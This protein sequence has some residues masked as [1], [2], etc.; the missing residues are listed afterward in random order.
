MADRE[1]VELDETITSLDLEGVFVEEIVVVTTEVPENVANELVAVTDGEDEYVGPTE[2]VIQDGLADDDDNVVGLVDK[3]CVSDVVYVADMIADHV[4][5]EDV[6]DADDEAVVVRVREFVIV[7]RREGDT[8]DEDVAEKVCTSRGEI[9]I[10][11]E[12]VPASDWLL[13]DDVDV[14]G[15]EEMERRGVLLAEDDAVSDFDP[16]TDKVDDGVCDDVRDVDV[17]RVGSRELDGEFDNCAEAE[18]LFDT[19]AD[20]VS[21]AEVDCDTEMRALAD[22]D[23]DTFI[24]AEAET[25][26]IV[27]R[28]GRATVPDD[29]GE[30][31]DDAELSV[32]TVAEEPLED[33]A[34]CI[35]VPVRTIDEVNIGKFEMVVDT[36]AD[37]DMRALCVTDTSLV[38]EADAEILYSIDG[39]NT[40]L[41]VADDVSENFVTDMSDETVLDCDARVEKELEF[42]SEGF[43]DDDLD[44][45]GEDVRTLESEYCVVSE[46]ELVV[47]ITTVD[48]PVA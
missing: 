24:D 5:Q 4:S 18:I 34:D 21:E 7:V 45:T 10:L 36:V 35:V 47:D 38:T 6:G 28:E 42:V 13:I 15:V 11:G 29:F 12:L 41:N 20:R 37:F 1:A 33:V 32:D 44:T 27:V 17:V 39:V 2:A 23:I 46:A 25:L 40:V 48:V 19:I 8:E 16:R 43:G 9:D 30:L 3:V 31:V 14:E 26:R 22:V